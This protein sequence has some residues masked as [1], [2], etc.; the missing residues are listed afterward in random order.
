MDV[1]WILEQLTKT[2]KSRADLARALGRDPAA[3]HR[4]LAGDRQIKLAEVEKI[5]NF[6]NEK[7]VTP[8]RRQLGREVPQSNDG[9]ESTLRVLGMAEG[10]PDG[11]NI[12]NGDVV[13]HIRRPDNLIGVPGAYAVYIRGGSMDPRYHAGELI[14]IHP[15]KP[16]TPGC[17]V[18]VQK[19]PN[20]DGEPP[21]AIVKQLVR[22]SASK[23]TLAQLSPAKDFEVRADEIL[24][25]HRIVGSSES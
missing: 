18:L 9:S 23:V 3:I 21:L 8:E 13:Q 2:G 15:G 7:G 24:S 5:R 4:L 6:F 14:H 19:R 16:V 1:P 10:G 22:R 12:W 20:A 25:M 11:W 17:Y